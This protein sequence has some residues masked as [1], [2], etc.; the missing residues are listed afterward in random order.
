MSVRSL[1][2]ALARVASPVTPNVPSIFVLPVATSTSN[3]VPTSNVVPSNVKFASSPR[4]PLVPAITIRLSVRSLTVAV[5]ITTSPVP[6]GVI[7][8][9]PSVSV[10]D[11]VLPLML[12]LSTSKSPVMSALATSVSVV[13]SKVK[14]ASSSSS[15]PVPAITTRLS[16]KSS[17]MALDIVAPLS[18]FNEPVKL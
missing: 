14:L 6:F 18:T 3:F 16:V 9:L 10:L 13:P 17:I 11:K 15:P 2:I 5:L 8:I 4:E 7:L 1:T 12:I